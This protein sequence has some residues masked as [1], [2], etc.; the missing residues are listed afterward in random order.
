[1]EI[2]DHCD[3]RAEQAMIEAV[4][5]AS[6]ANLPQEATGH[7]KGRDSTEVA[8]RAAARPIGW[9][10]RPVGMFIGRPQQ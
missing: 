2:H 3:G 5:R 9:R 6:P 7:M 1:M 8:A 4:A 10:R